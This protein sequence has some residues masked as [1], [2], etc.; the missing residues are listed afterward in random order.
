[1][2]R[3]LFGATLV[4]SAFLLFLVQPMVARAV[5]PWFGGSASL[6]TGCMLFFQAMLLVGYL[7]SHALVRLTTAARQARIHAV[8]LAGALLLLPPVPGP[9]WKPADLQNPPVQIVLLLLAVVGL[10]YFVLAAT[11]PLMQS[12]YARAVPGRSPY[13]LY[14]WSNASSLLALVA[15]PTIIEPVLPLRWQ[16]FLW[17]GLFGLFVALGL[18]CAWAMAKAPASLAAAGRREGMRPPGALV[19]PKPSLPQT[20]TWLWLACLPSVLLLGTTNELCQDIASVPFLWVLPLA[21]YLLTFVLCFQSDRVY[22][23]GAMLPL[24]LACILAT[25]LSSYVGGD[26]PLWADIAI[27]CAT[28]FVFCLICHGELVRRRPPAAHLTRFYLVVALGGALGG[29]FVAVVAP[30]LFSS[31]LELP[32]A[33]AAVV[34]T[35]ALVLASTDG[36]SPSWLRVRVSG[37]ALGVLYIV[38]AGLVTPHARSAADR[39][40]LVLDQRRNFFGVV[41][42][43]E[44]PA[45]IPGS[46]ARWLYNGR[47]VH[48]IQLLAPGLRQKPVTYYSEGSGVGLA[49]HNLGNAGGRH[50]GVVGLGIGTLAAYGRSGDR[51]R[52][53]DIN[54]LVEEFARQYFTFVSGS[55]C[56]V[57]VVPGDARVNL[58]REPPQQFDLLALDAFSSDAIPTHLLTVEA[59]RTYLRHLRPDGV[60]AVHISN[61]YFDLTPVLRGLAE[62]TGLTG[63]LVRATRNVD[64]HIYNTR[65][66]LMS[67][68][69]GLPDRPWLRSVADGAWQQ[70]SPRP[71]TDDFTSLLGILRQDR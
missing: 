65:W 15:Y 2:V 61:A 36:L 35:S 21:L 8:L 55:A 69:P 13:R 26:P 49:L 59:A 17:S 66:V 29:A 30:L 18:S 28:L 68:D 33:L 12:W 34:V 22:W 60:L 39:G 48:G 32:I 58:E 64:E 51:M 45:A 41:R 11:A 47:I 62:A 19:P 42:V 10:P 63:A 6:W 53:Y 4:L 57:E 50:I 40:R 46:D 24:S 3:R 31:F 25:G 54:P 38:A 7:Y 37:T 5:L 14:A 20:A 52:F 27:W 67:R 1:M 44:G 43:E 9:A 70:A 56:R 16:G 23:R 71:W